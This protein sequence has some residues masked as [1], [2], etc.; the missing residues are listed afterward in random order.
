VVEVGLD[1]QEV[2]MSVVVVA[3][4]DL[5]LEHLQRQDLQ[6]IQS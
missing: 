4:A 5:E 1:L 3:L 6:V 2:D